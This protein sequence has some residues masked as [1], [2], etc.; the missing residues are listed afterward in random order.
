LST[1]TNLRDP[2]WAEEEF[3]PVA[4]KEVRL[5][6]RCQ[7]LAGALEQ[8]PMVPLNQACEDWADTKAAYRF[9]DNPQ[10]SP[11]AILAP[12]CQRTVERMKAHSLVLAVQ[13]TTFF[14][15]T[16]HPQTEGLGEIGTKEQ[17]QRGFGMHTTLALTPDGLPLGLLTQ[18]FFTRPVGEPAHT[19]TALRKLP[20][21]EKESYRWLEALEQ[22]MALTPVQV[23]VVTVCDREADI[24]EL[25]ALAAQRQAS[26]LVRASADRCLA[27][28]KVKHLWDKVERRRR[29]GE[30]TVEITGNQQHPA[31][32]ATV[33]LR[34]CQVTLK[35]PV[36]PRSQ[37]KLPPVTLTALLV[38]EEHPPADIDE[39]IEWLLL[40]NTAVRS[41][42]EAVQ[43]VDWYGGRWQI[44]VY[45]KI[46]KSGCTVEACRLQTA[47]RLQNYIALMSVVAWRLHWLTYI[48]RCDPHQ[49]CTVVLTTPEWQALYLR[50]HKT[51]TFPKKLPTVHQVIRWIAQLGGFLGRKADGEPGIT[52]MWRGW[53]RL[54][55][56]AA[57][58][59]L[60]V[61]E[62]PKLMGNR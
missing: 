46:L 16:A 5:N 38:R 35:P 49:P 26:L 1:K 19:P 25:F 13:D 33:S 53:Q 23:Q 6:R 4:L 39:P 44:E 20:I 17:H 56:M 10:V 11:V 27:E 62:R 22:T 52:V 28:N 47:D 18:A 43:V 41:L 7:V 2:S 3:A 40:T 48:N 21:E 9:M 61:N 55:D 31:R 14:N 58:W 54:Q 37:A 45:H 29:V 36:R 60:I 34:F 42:A 57:T 24:Y 30:L 15:Y 59:Y 51:M 50:I 12:H 32:Q 8:Q